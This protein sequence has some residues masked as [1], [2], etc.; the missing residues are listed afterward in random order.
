MTDPGDAVC[1]EDWAPNKVFGGG[2]YSSGKTI[3]TWLQNALNLT[4]NDADRLPE[5]A[6]QVPL[7]NLPPWASMSLTCSMYSCVHHVRLRCRQEA[8]LQRMVST[9]LGAHTVFNNLTELSAC[10]EEIA[11][12]YSQLMLGLGF[13]HGFE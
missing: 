5:C 11:A 7:S 2:E 8:Y 13:S 6:F 10:M 4:L 3:R 9:H 1:A 12:L